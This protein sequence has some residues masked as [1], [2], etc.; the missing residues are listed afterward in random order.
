L[1]VEWTLGPIP[2]EEDGVGKEVIAR[3]ETDVGSENLLYT[4]ANG[5]EFQKRKL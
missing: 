2:V 5:R 1:E 4:D 3:F